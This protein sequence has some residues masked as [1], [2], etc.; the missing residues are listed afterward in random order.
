MTTRDASYQPSV[1]APP[2][3]TTA[4]YDGTEYA[5]FPVNSVA[6]VIMLC[7]NVIR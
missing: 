4:E 3:A 5:A 6:F 7:P 2:R 1:I